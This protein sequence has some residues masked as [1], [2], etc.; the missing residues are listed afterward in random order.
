MLIHLLACVMT[1]AS[2]WS[3][4]FAQP[5]RAGAQMPSGCTT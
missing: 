4:T 3:P 5:R 2:G 1:T